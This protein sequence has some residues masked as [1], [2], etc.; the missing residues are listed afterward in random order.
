MMQ[1]CQTQAGFGVEISC[2]L[3]NW[4]R[5]RSE[6]GWRGN[7]GKGGRV[8][9]RTQPLRPDIWTRHCT[10]A[11]R[12]AKS[13]MLSKNRPVPCLHLQAQVGFPFT[14]LRGVG[15]RK[16]SRCCWMPG[17]T[18]LQLMATDVRPRTWRRSISAKSVCVSL[19]RQSRRLMQAG[20][21]S[22]RRGLQRLGLALSPRPSAAPP[23][24]YPQHTPDSFPSSFV[25]PSH[26][27]IEN[28]L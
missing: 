23:L 10:E 18:H 24:F 22:N 12:P 15:W 5:R 17:P 19:T 8:A 3:E 26:S 2:S 21:E 11:T 27:L 4:R 6:E 20:A 14:S 25:M 1:H 9:R 13:R 7:G 28:L 16:P